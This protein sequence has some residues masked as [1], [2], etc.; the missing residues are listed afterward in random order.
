M[1]LEELEQKKRELELRSQIAHL[2]RK[3]RFVAAVSKFDWHLLWAIPCV[4][5]G[6]S[7]L[8]A[9]GF[10]WANHPDELIYLI[11]FVVGAALLIPPALR[12]R[13]LRRRRKVAAEI[14]ER[15]ERRKETSLTLAISLSIAA[16]CFS[17]VN[18]WIATFGVETFPRITSALNHPAALTELIAEAAGGS[19][20]FPLK[21]V[22]IASIFKSKRN[23][24]ARR[25]IFIGWAIV[26]MLALAA[27][28]GFKGEMKKIDLRIPPGVSHPR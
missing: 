6:I 18:T 15:T 4:L 12:W 3:E 5:G 7:Y 26:T 19:L 13:Y 1:I 24:S 14:T 23:S 25:R 11:G 22:A 10:S 27:A 28:L 20:L 21:H 2:E 17:F 16:F 9:G 8:L